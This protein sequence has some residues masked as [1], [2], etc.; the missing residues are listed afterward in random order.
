MTNQIEVCDYSIE[1]LRRLISEKSKSNE[2]VIGSKLHHYYFEGYCDFIGVKT[3][4]VENNYID[5][6]YLE[7]F[8]AY[9]V[10]CFSTYQRVCTRLHFFGV[11]FSQAD[12]E[13][14]LGK[15]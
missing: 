14:Y 15:V 9:Y 6:D 4:V 12:F 11:Q 10:R 7:D 8:S 5:H 1:T 2:D 13:Q 3:I